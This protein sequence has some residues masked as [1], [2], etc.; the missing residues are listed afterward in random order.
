MRHLTR[1]ELLQAG[2]AGAAA[3]AL[4]NALATRPKHA[5]RLGIQSY[6]LRGFDRDA[7]LLR[8]RELGLTQW[9]AFQAHVP[10]TGDPLV[11]AEV[12][13]AMRANGVKLTAWGVQGYGADEALTRRAFA[14][15]Q[16]LGIEVLSADP[17]PESLALLG[18][19]SEATGIKVAIH[20]H[21]P[22]SRYDKLE[23]VL[24]ALDAS[25]S[26]VGVC[27]DTGHALRSRED[28]VEWAKRLKGRVYGVHLKDVKDA[29]QFK[30]LGQGDLRL[31]PFLA[32]LAAQKFE[33]P[34]N[35][36]YEENPQ[37]P[38]ADLK[39]CLAAVHAAM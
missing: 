13:S 23:S 39:E 7:A 2:A 11:L 25:K 34:L 33:G 15:A 18:Q 3:L 28:P 12:R 22:N 10:L 31:K 36:E 29:T 5:F 37:N 35:I 26:G 6:S 21:G 32:E 16:A 8:T 27:I 17:A 20:N 4:P 24:R 38:M 30:I 1:R 19:L 9:E 14:F